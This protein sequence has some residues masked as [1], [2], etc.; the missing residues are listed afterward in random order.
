MHVHYRPANYVLDY[1]Q[2]VDFVAVVGP[3]AVGKNSVVEE[4]AK[5]DPDVHW[6]PFTTSRPSRPGEK[7]GV[8]YQFRSRQEMEERIQRAEYVNVAPNLL[9]DLYGS[10]PE[11][12]SQNGVATAAVLA[13]AVATFRSL[14]FK[15]LKTIFVL[16]PSWDEWQKRIVKHGFTS[17]QLQKRLK[18]AKRSL[19]F[20]LHDKQT[21]FV[22]NDDL[23]Q[24][25]QDFIV[26]AHG[27]ELSY[28][29]KQSQKDAVN[30]VRNLL[31]NL[32]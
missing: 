7:P 6:V 17:K 26:L 15:S 1:L 2:K 9:G 11:D 18:E 14:P 21:Q 10:A 8:E 4:A 13:D 20:A 24:A 12:Y 29:L 5:R 19:N 22:I 25:A 27:K 28:R 32:G 30:F 31:D 16:P 3:T 23:T